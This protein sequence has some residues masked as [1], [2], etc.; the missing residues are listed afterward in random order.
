MQVGAGETS[1]STVVKQD[2]SWQRE[3]HQEVRHCQVDGVDHRGGLL[4][5]AETENIKR[6]NVEHHANLEEIE[7]CQLC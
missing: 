6:H 1:S 5:G 7:F 4:L 2:A 3:I